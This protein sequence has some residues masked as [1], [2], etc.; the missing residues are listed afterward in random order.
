[1]YFATDTEQEK[2]EWM[3]AFRKGSHVQLVIV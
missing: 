2:K 3:S 1:M